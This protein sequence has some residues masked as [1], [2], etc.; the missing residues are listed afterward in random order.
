MKDWECLTK[1]LIADHESVNQIMEVI[2]KAAVVS[3]L[4]VKM[5]DKFANLIELKEL[6][7][8]ARLTFR[9]LSLAW[10]SSSWLSLDNELLPNLSTGDELPD[11]KHSQKFVEAET[12][13]FI[14][15][16]KSSNCLMCF[17]IKFMATKQGVKQNMSKGIQRAHAV[18]Q[19]MSGIDNSPSLSA[20]RGIMTSAYFLVC[21]KEHESWIET[22]SENSQ[23]DKSLRRMAS[24]S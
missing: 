20:P 5:G 22:K 9:T 18:T 15:V 13:R 17:M 14:R 3:I 24:R 21:K 12:D 4:I 1:K 8:Q 10:R 6:S 16:R 23:V 19:R 7:F 11:S 2:L